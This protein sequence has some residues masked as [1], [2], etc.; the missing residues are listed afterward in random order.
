M[1]LEGEGLGL[2]DARLRFV[3]SDELGPGLEAP[4]GV[5]RICI[6]TFSV[7]DTRRLFDIIAGKYDTQSSG[8]SPK[9]PVRDLCQSRVLT[10]ASKVRC[11]DPQRKGFGYELQGCE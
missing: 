5:N 6:I 9:T 4:G 7:P 8:G 2:E 3:A 11:F 10:S 1:L